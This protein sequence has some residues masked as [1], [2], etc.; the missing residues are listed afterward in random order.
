ML[1]EILYLL[2]FNLI[3]HFRWYP[4]GHGDFY[5]SFKNSGLLQKFIDTVCF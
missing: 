3:L 5:D 1:I 4:P 2:K